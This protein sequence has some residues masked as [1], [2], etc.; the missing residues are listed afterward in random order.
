MTDTYFAVMGY[1][2]GSRPIPPVGQMMDDF[3]AEYG[4]GAAS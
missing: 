1:E 3:R 2:D 4:P